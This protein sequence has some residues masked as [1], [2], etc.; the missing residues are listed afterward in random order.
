[1]HSSSRS[2]GVDIVAADQ[3]SVTRALVDLRRVRGWADSVEVAAAARLADL[4]EKSP[5]I[6]PERV[7]AD[8]GRVSLIEATRGFDRAKTVEMIPELGAVLAVGDTSAGSCRRRHPGPA[9]SRREQRRRLASRGDALALGAATL[10]RDEFAKAVRRELRQLC[11][12]DGMARLER[13]K[14]ATRLRTW[15]DRETGMW[16]LRGE[17]DPEAGL[18]LDL[19]LQAMVDSLFHDKTPE[20]A[21]ADPVSKQQHLR[22]LALAALCDGKGGK[23]RTEVTVLIDAQTLLEGEHAQTYVD[24]GLDIDLPIET[25]RRMATSADVLTPV[26]TAANGINLHLGRSKRLAS[27]DQRRILRVMYP[28]C[29]RPGCDVPFDKTEIHHIDWYGQDH[30][31]TDIDDLAPLCH[32]D[33]RTHPRTSLRAVHRPAAEPHPPVPGWNHDDNRPTQTRRRVARQCDARQDW[34]MHRS[35]S[36]HTIAAQLE[37]IDDRFSACR[38]DSR[39]E[40]HFDGCRWAEG[41]VYVPAGRYLVW[42]DIPNDRMLRWDEM[43]GRVGLFRQPAGYSNGNTLDRDG[44]LVTCQHGTRQVTRTEHDGSIAVLADTYEGK[45][46][47]SPNDVVVHSDGTIW[48]TDPAYG[49]DSDYEGHRAESEIGALLRVPPRSCRRVSSASSPTTSCGRTAWR[50]RST[51]PTCTSSTR[52]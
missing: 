30:G 20:T 32:A 22:A 48:F 40:R 24:L 38:G 13:Q 6:F 12:D 17:F 39:I 50:S 1:M 25:I 27:R 5:S 7:V 36:P 26:I 28:T 21:P 44:R 33:H 43:S 31:K 15:T 8:A 35:A 34:D 45:R 16:C 42:S 18:V 49:I 4:A 2:S 46:L 37:V 51:R 9:R 19:K 52:G 3:A 10:P 47:N 41:P 11:A 23:V 14:R 29:A